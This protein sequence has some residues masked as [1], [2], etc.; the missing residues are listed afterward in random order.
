MR[1]RAGEQTGA[2]RTIT[3]VSGGAGHSGCRVPRPPDTG[4]VRGAESSG[5]SRGARPMRPTRT[6][7]TCRRPEKAMR[8]PA[9]RS[10][11]PKPVRR[12]TR[13]GPAVGRP[14][15]APPAW[16]S[17]S[18]TTVS[19]ADT[20][21][22]ARGTA[23]TEIEQEP[24]LRRGPVPHERLP[25]TAVARDRPSTG[26]PTS[27]RRPPLEAAP[28]MYTSLL[29]SLHLAGIIAELLPMHALYAYSMGAVVLRVT[30]PRKQ[31]SASAAPCRHGTSPA[32]RRMR[33]PAASQE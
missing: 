5:T 26:R 14:L 25:R 12:R 31:A 8:R 17:S 2:F 21:A 30:A 24:E 22:P 29:A 18:D 11:T 27:R 4:V 20:I 33:S 3:P 16:S 6:R 10:R 23:R 32:G 13:G 15:P 28:E 19:G 9:R 7:W 1:R